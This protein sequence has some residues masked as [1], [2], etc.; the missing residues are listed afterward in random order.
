MNPEAFALTHIGGPTLLIEIG[1]L[2]LLTDP[3][4][5]AKGGTYTIPRVG[6]VTQKVA[7]PI[8]SVS[9]LGRI[10]AVL[11]SHDE[12]A[13]NLDDAGRALLAHVGATYTTTAGALRL[14]GSAVGLAPWQSTALGEITITATPGRHG[15]PGCEPLLGDV[16]GFVLAWSG[17]TNGALYVSGDTVWYEELAEIGR[18]HVIGTAILHLGRVELPD[19]TRFTMSATDGAAAARALG[20]HR[21]VPVHYDGWQHF[22]E[23]RDAADAI[24]ADAGLRE[25]VQWL[26]PGRRTAFS[27]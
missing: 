8:V 1:S 20:V 26:E 22:T 11:L 7:D 9:A 19:G 5:D 16:T 17:Q 27:R 15:P 10:D 14:G 21:I 2:R 3:T 18:R 24:F 4:L 13:D 12:H 25:E 23:G 6:A